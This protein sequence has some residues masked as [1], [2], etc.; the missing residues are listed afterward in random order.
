[1]S[2]SQNPGGAIAGT[3]PVY[4]TGSIQSGAP[5]WV[6]R[7]AT[8]SAFQSAFDDA[9]AGGFRPEQ[10]QGVQVDGQTLYNGVWT[11]IDGQFESY[12]SMTLSFFASNWSEM[13]ELELTLRV[14]CVGPARPSAWGRVFHSVN[15]RGMLCRARRRLA[16]QD[17]NAVRGE[18]RSRMLGHPFNYDP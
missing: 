18:L 11:P 15:S 4:M 17:L 9:F 5:R 14:V 6:R 16:L 12:N 7:L 10:V 2:A 3:G 1:M 13:G 8:S